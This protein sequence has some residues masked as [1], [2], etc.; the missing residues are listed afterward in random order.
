VDTF[1]SFDGTRLAYHVA[2]DG[3]P[4]LVLPGGPMHAS[5]YLGDLGGLTRHRTLYLLDP[6][7]TGG[8][9]HPAD[10]SSYRCDRQVADVEAFREHLGLESADLLAHSAGANLAI[11]HA[12]RHPDRVG[13]LALIAPSLRA[14]GIEA[15]EEQLREAAAFRAG[16]PWFAEVMAAFDAVFAGTATEAD[17]QTLRPL[18]YGRWDTTTQEHAARDAAQQ[19]SEAAGLFYAGAFDPPETRRALADLAA[20]VLLVAGEIDGSP[21]PSMV[22]EVAPVFPKAETAVVPGGGHFPWLDDP[23]SF[24]RVVRDFLDD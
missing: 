17:R 5:E 11:L 18:F 9:A 1:E 10:A 14:L 8:S 12:A 3:E 20:P 4:L 22:R 19:N 2:G 23:E 13:R 7:G 24:T 21:R 16:Q 15:T 6:R